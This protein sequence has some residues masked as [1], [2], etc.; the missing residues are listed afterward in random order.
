[1]FLSLD[2][3]QERKIRSLYDVFKDEFEQADNVQG[4][5]LRML[6]VRLIITITRIGKLQYASETTAEDSRFDLYR[7]FNLM[8]E[9]NYK[10]K[11]EVQFYASALNKS[12]KTLS[13]VFAIHARKTPSQ[14]IYE[15]ITLEA[16]RLLLYTNKSIK[17]IYLELGFD[18]ASHFGR[19][20][21]RATGQTPSDFKK[22]INQEYNL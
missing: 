4:E 6:L 11:H 1:M 8:V 19:F 20:F 9:A 18:D 14:I 3:E 16:K 17:E 2:A 10:L 22:S 5:M 13:N 12:P 21:K 15:R 7:K